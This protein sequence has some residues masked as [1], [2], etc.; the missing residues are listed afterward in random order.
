LNLAT[1]S[2]IN[3]LTSVTEL[4]SGGSLRLYSGTQPATPETTLSGNTLLATF[5]FASPAFGSASLT[6]GNEQMTASFSPASVAPG[7]NGTVTFARA[8]MLVGTWTGNATYSYGNIVTNSSNLYFCTKAGTANSSGGPTTTVP[9]ITD[10][11]VQWQYLG[12]STATVVADF[13]VGT[14]GTDIIIGNSVLSTTINVTITSFILQIP[15]V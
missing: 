7:N 6:G 13:T 4:L 9:S 5:T 3:A 10:G 15:A 14:S 8:S 2:A 11:T 1:V 12:A